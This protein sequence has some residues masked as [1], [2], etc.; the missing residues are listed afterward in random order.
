MP[1]VCGVAFESQSRVVQTV[2]ERI[3]FGWIALAHQFEGAPCVPGGFFGRIGLQNHALDDTE[4]ALLI[5]EEFAERD[6]ES[7]RRVIAGVHFQGA[8]RNRDRTPDSGGYACRVTL[9]R[10]HCRHE[11]HCDRSHQHAAYPPAH[12][13]PPRPQLKASTFG[14]NSVTR[15]RHRLNLPARMISTSG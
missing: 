3:I 5:S 9:E 1:G 10:E 4:D 6:I 15:M 13:L 8:G 14:L 7:G 2:A 12:D 11:N